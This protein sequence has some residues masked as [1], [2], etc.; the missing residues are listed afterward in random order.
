MIFNIATVVIILLATYWYAFKEGF[1]SGFVHLACVIVAGGLTFAFWE[2]LAM[3]MI[4]TG[5][6]EFAWGISILGLFGF[7]LII[8]RIITNLTIPH[9][10]NFPNLLDVIGGGATGLCSGIITAGIGFLPIGNTFADGQLGWT[11]KSG[12]PTSQTAVI[13]VHNWTEAFYANLSA[14]AFK[15]MV[16]RGNLKNDYP[17][18]ANQAWSLHR[19]T[20]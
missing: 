12:Q 2:P 10:Q 13:P 9:R 4:G 1:F 8:L 15:P 14:G 17:G 3:T 5:V 19:D 16:N 11:R 18:L 7:S 6:G 20:A